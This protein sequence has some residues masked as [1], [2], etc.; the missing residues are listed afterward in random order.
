MNTVSFAIAKE[1]TKDITVTVSESG[2]CP[3]CSSI[4]LF[5]A[6]TQYFDPGSI[7]IGTSSEFDSLIASHPLLPDKGVMFILSDCSVPNVAHCEKVSV[8]KTNQQLI[9]LFNLINSKKSELDNWTEAL[10]EISVT[11]GDIERLINEASKMIRT[12]IMMSGADYK[13]IKHSVH[14]EHLRAEVLTRSTL[15]PL[16][17]PEII[18]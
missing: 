17:Y 1:W 15:F 14:V 3:K 7:Y 18:V 13:F 11:S 9:P 5:D 2:V 6:N 4:A 10:R 12:N 16:K 8:I